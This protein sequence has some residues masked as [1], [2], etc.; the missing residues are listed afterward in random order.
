MRAYEDAGET[1][2]AKS[3]SSWRRRHDVLP[4]GGPQ[5]AASVQC[6]QWAAGN[7]A[8]AALLAR[9]R[10]LVQR[11]GPVPCDCSP[12]ERQAYAKA[13][14]AVQ[15]EDD[16]ENQSTDPMQSTDPEEGGSSQVPAKDPMEGGLSAGDGGSSR[17]PMQ[18]G[19]S[20]DP[21]LDGGF[22]SPPGAQSRDPWVGGS[23]EG[24]APLDG[25]FTPA[26]GAQS[27]EEDDPL[28]GG[29]SQG[30]APGPPPAVATEGGSSREPNQSNDPNEGGSS[31]EPICD[32]AKR[33]GAYKA[34]YEHELETRADVETTKIAY[35]QARTMRPA[36]IIA[37]GLPD[38]KALSEADWEVQRTKAAY[39]AAVLKNCHALK[40]TAQAHKDAGCPTAHPEAYSC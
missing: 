19:S 2:A 39:D 10:V 9:E 14:K 34:A 7:A 26:P 8:I 27:K 37:G 16:E 13:A 24:P 4:P 29:S 33:N 1:V 11:C 21:G 40:A 38:P 22:S 28:L 12:D 3:A 5:N 25:G 36:R 18:G 17:D 32:A 15:R 31:Q 30:P 6:L 23:S 35:D 20:Q